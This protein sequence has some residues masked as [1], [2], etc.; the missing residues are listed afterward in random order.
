MG[1]RRNA[2]DGGDIFQEMSIRNSRK[3]VALT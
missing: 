2:Q 1:C 3:P